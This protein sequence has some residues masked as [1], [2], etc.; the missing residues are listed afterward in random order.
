VSAENASAEI[1]VCYVVSDPRNIREQVIL[2]SI[3]ESLVAEAKAELER[4]PLKGRVTLCLATNYDAVVPPPPSWFGTLRQAHH[5]RR[6]DVNAGAKAVAGLGRNHG[7]IL[8]HAR[9]FA[10]GDSFT[11]RRLQDGLDPNRIVA[12]E[13]WHVVLQQQ[14]E[15][16]NS[17]KKR[18]RLP[19]QA[20]HAQLLFNF[21]EEY[22][23]ELALC[24]P[25]GLRL[26]GPAEREQDRKLFLDDA[27]SRLLNAIEL[28]SPQ[29]DQF[30]GALS[31]CYSLGLRL[32]LIAAEQ[33]A[34]GEQRIEESRHS[35][36]Y[37]R[38]KERWDEAMAAL[39]EVPAADVRLD[40]EV[41]DE[42]ARNLARISYVWLTRLRT[43]G[44]DGIPDLEPW[45]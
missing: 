10:C 24:Q 31:L 15:D 23:V 4:L 7:L 45:P 36:Q 30:S 18:L 43:N 14:G 22:R 41:L 16:S 35:R 34:S 40:P 39:N 5:M 26:R 8:T 38:A 20:F 29:E 6:L 44:V 13:G 37:P 12:H 19:S 25:P 1:V 9:F 27:W 32:A 28:P 17:L 11:A 3:D 42:H 2:E 33:R 21:L